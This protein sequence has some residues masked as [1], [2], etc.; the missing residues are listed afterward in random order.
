MPLM[1]SKIVIDVFTSQRSKS[2]FF[3]FKFNVHGRMHI[4]DQR[5]R[6][7]ISFVIV[8]RLGRFIVINVPTV[9][10]MVWYNLKL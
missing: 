1:I 9:V 7:R 4:L 5:R 10:G 3:I 2:E 8:L 6:F